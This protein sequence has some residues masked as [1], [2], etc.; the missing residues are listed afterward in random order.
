MECILSGAAIPVASHGFSHAHSR[1]P[2]PGS[3]RIGSGLSLIIFVLGPIREPDQT[4]QMPRKY[5]SCGCDNKD[6][7]FLS[8]LQRHT[9]VTHSSSWSSKGNAFVRNVR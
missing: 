2:D 5:A 8:D 6:H 4:G 9:K 1:S 7:H 3:F